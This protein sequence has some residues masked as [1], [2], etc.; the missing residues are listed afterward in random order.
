VI[1]IKLPSAIGPSVHSVA[2]HEIC[3]P[4]TYILSSVHPQ[5]C[6]LPLHHVVFEL[7]LIFRLVIKLKVT[8][9]VLFTL[10]I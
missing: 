4:F 1:F 9:T 8:E 7:S 3:I 5:T 2:V 6:A 10:Q